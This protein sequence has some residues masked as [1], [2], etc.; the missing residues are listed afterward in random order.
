MFPVVATDEQF[1]GI[2]AQRT[3]QQIQARI[4]QKIVA[5]S[6]RLHVKLHQ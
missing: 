4:D 2:L 6:Q 3:W 5:I 1:L